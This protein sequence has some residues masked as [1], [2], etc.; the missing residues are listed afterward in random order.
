MADEFF[1]RT[2]PPAAPLRKPAGSGRLVVGVAT[3]SFLLGGA[4]V[5]WMA[6]Y[7]QIDLGDQTSK[8]A[9]ARLAASPSASA[10]AEPSAAGSAAATA[11]TLPALAATAGLEQRLVQMEQRLNAL[12]LRAQAATGNAA[13]AEG[14]LIAL[15]S[16]RAI[17]RGMPLGTLEDQLR[18]RFGDAQPNAV[19][20]AIEAARQPV[21]LDRLD[22]GLQTLA[23]K[24]Q[25][26]AADE[27]GWDRFRRQIMGMFVVRRS[28]SASA[29]PAQ[30]LAQA[31]LLLRSGQVEAAA[32]LVAS[33]PGAGSASSWIAEARRYASAQQALD[34]IEAAAILEPRQLQDGAGQR[35]EQTSPAVQPVEPSGEPSV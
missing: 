12:D 10:S 25:Q 33:L 3:L 32:N 20:L 1:A 15:A 34:Q 13:R 2:P 19:R 17:E 21:T 24:L 29:E 26:A 27:N 22:S 30:R 18:L 8:E 16:R 31:R 28:A 5:G 14:L 7:G 6:Y 9:P 11:A 35:I 4:L 23:A